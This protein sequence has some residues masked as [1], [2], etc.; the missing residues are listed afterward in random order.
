[1]Q[2]GRQGN[3]GSQKRGFH[4]GNIETTAIGWPPTRK[5][6][7]SQ[8]SDDTLD[9]V[10]RSVLSVVV[11]GALGGRGLLVQRNRGRQSIFRVN[12]VSRALSCFH[13][14]SFH[15]FISSKKLHSCFRTVQ[16]RVY[17]G[18]KPNSLTFIH[19]YL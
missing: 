2:N 4:I 14:H 5:L 19:M 9:I 6:E 7:F 11:L 8:T 1:M 13:H 16:R 3:L 10:V 18:T 15:H 17:N 12:P